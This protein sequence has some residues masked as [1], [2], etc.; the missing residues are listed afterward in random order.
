M[1]FFETLPRNSRPLPTRNFDISGNPVDLAT[2]GTLQNA[3][4]SLASLAGEDFATQT[5]L[6]AILADTATMDTNLA[7][8]AAE[9]FATQTTLA[10]VLA[11]TATMDANLATLAAE[12]F[13][14][15]TTLAAI[16]ADTATIDTNVAKLNQKLAT[17]SHTTGTTNMD[18]D[19]AGMGGVFLD[20]S[21]TWVGDVSFSGSVDGVVFFPLSG[22]NVLLLDGQ[23][24][25]LT[26]VNGQFKFDVT[27]LKTFRAT[28]ALSSGTSLLRAASALSSGVISA[29]LNSLA[30]VSGTVSVDALPVA[31]NA[32]AASAT[33]QRVVIVTDQSAVPT[34]ATDVTA[35]G[36]ITT[37]NLVPAG[38][39]TAN[40]AV[41]SGTLNGNG[42]LTVQVTGTYTGALSLQGTVDNTTWVTVSFATFINVNTGAATTTI[43]SGTQG[44]FQTDCAG[45][46]QVRI[47]GLAAMTGTAVVT[48]RASTSA[49][50]VHVDS[51]IP[52]GTNVIGALSANQSVNVA[53]MNGVTT[54][55]GA[56]VSGTG[57][58]RV[59]LANAST[60]TL[61]NVA[62][63]ASN[64]T[65][66]A[67]SATRAGASFYNDSTALLYLK[68]G[69]T[70]S[71]TSFT[72]QIQ[73]SG[74][75]ELPTPNIYS[76]IID[77]IWSSATGSCRVTSW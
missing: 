2:E 31:F 60:A 10:A 54:T 15:E 70:A 38:A 49:N 14:T 8:L 72:V 56:G 53:Q 47:T 29:I 66:L 44:I 24:P 41:L 63:S 11:D 69:A 17:A 12:D 27:G 48:L 67:S 58:Q 39:A 5:T 33:T 25:L 40:S 71:V 32:G 77:G 3:A 9:D 23:I 36:N 18:L 13:A 21:G 45:F 61:A 30:I 35:T 64:V 73:P 6:A 16:L 1:V 55:M 19:V 62:G 59:V 57:V 26:N 50:F 51:P 20:I 68:F 37:Q 22:T 76:G 74:Y 34:V 52:A 7:S 65:L 28:S 46:R 75:Y 42:T 4:A 43:T